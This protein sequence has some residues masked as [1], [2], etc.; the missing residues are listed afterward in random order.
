[1]IKKKKAI[2]GH[3]LIILCCYLVTW[4]IYLLP[5]SKPTFA[6]ILSKPLFWGLVLIFGEVSANVHSY[7]KCIQGSGCL[8]NK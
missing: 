6:G 5:V 4:G 2:L 1:M 3:F 8:A 7:C